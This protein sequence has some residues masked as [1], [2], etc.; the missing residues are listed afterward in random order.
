MHSSHERDIHLRYAD[1]RDVAFHLKPDRWPDKP[2]DLLVH[3]FCVVEPGVFRHFLQF[4]RGV[5]IEIFF[6]GFDVSF[7]PPE[8]EERVKILNTTKRKKV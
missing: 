2:V 6:E 3:E 5:F 4:D 7:T 1:V 8:G